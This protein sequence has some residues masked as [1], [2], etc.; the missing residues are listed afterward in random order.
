MSIACT[1]VTRMADHGR[2]TFTAPRAVTLPTM[3]LAAIVAA[4]FAVGG[5]Y[6]IFGQSASAIGPMQTRLAVVES[7]NFKQGLAIDQ[8]QSKIGEIGG[9]FESASAATTAQ[10]TQLQIS[11]A[12]LRV[13]VNGIAKASEMQLPGDQKHK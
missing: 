2:D 11:I 5:V 13:I 6:V 12:E 9:R 8:L 4:A 1:W 10:F 3:L 7:D